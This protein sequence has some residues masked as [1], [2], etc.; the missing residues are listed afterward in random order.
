[1]K[2]N[3]P[4]HLARLPKLLAGKN[5][6]RLK[7][8]DYRG[9]DILD[10]LGDWFN[11]S[12][13]YNLLLFADEFI[14]K[15]NENGPL[16]YR[17]DKK[18]VELD[19]HY[20]SLEESFPLLKWSYNYC[21]KEKLPLYVIHGKS[22]SKYS[23][24]K[25]I[26]D[27]TR[28]LIVMMSHKKYCTYIFSEDLKL[29]CGAILIN[30]IIPLDLIKIYSFRDLQTNVCIVNDN[31]GLI[32]NREEIEIA[33]KSDKNGF[34]TAIF[35]KDNEQGEIINKICECFNNDSYKIFYGKYI[36]ENNNYVI[37]AKR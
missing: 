15:H 7:N 29:D 37:I 5:L 6:E 34:V 10:Y 8:P 24:L 21:C 22:T 25:S 2:I 14:E 31:N 17:D 3:V 30:P 27:L 19:L 26:K 4:V 13:E 28:I 33:I 12:H 9:Q 1:M 36:S 23:E 11:Y 35:N 32:N 18:W 20:H 16:F